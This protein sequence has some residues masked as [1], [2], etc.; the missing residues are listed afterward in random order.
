MLKKIFPLLFVFSFLFLMGCEGKVVV[1]PTDDG[2]V[3]EKEVIPEESEAQKPKLPEKADEDVNVI[4]TT[5]E[6]IIDEDGQDI[7][8]V[9]TEV[10]DEGITTSIHIDTNPNP[11]GVEC[12]SFTDCGE[13][14]NGVQKAC[15]QEKCVEA[16]CFWESDC[17]GSLCFDYKCQ[18]PDDIY[19]QFEK[20]Y[21]GSNP[22]KDI[23]CENC[24]QGY[25]SCSIKGEGDLEVRFCTDCISDYDC[26]DGYACVG[27][28][29]Q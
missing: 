4:G 9:T 10:T 26:N 18:M 2:V 22:C 21:L 6:D 13:G 24:K 19:S 28:V 15:I 5:T 29:C 25:K 8:E 1:T 3:V 12:N 27:Y 14:A 23:A 20:C 16:E 11:E 7:G 17:T